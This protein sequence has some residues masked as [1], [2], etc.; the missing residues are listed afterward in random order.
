MI[1]IQSESFP[2]MLD[3]GRPSFYA[4]DDETRDYL[5]TVQE[6]IR[7]VDIEIKVNGFYHTLTEMLRTDAGFLG[8][9]FK[10]CFWFRSVEDRDQFTKQLSGI[11]RPVGWRWRHEITSLLTPPV[12]PV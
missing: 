8:G 11:P 12:I 2:I 4:G 7:T 3:I 9:G 1:S 6:W 10:Y 5:Y